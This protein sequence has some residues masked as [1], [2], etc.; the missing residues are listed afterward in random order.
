M[1]DLIKKVSFA[2]C[3]RCF[4]LATYYKKVE[5]VCP[6]CNCKLSIQTVKIPARL[7]DEDVQ[8]SAIVTRIP[9]YGSMRRI[10]GT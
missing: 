3:P 6:N 10:N 8:N 5:S 4:W 7:Q 9:H 2:L 1:K